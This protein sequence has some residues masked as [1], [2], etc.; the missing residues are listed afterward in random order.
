MPFSKERRGNWLA[1]TGPMMGRAGATTAEPAAGRAKRK[2]EDLS[3]EQGAA[4]GRGAAGAGKA[5][6][7]AKSMASSPP[8]RSPERVSQ[9][10]TAQKE[11]A[12]A[13]EAAAAATAD[14]SAEAESEWRT[15]GSA[16]VG[17][18]ILRTVQDDGQLSEGWGKI[19]GWLSAAESDFVNDD[20][21]P[22]ALWHVVFDD[23][24]L[25]EEDL[26]EH[27]V[28]AAVIAWELATREL[29]RGGKKNSKASAA[30]KGKKGKARGAESDAVPPARDPRVYFVEDADEH[31]GLPQL[32]LE[33]E[34]DVED[35]I[36]LNSERYKGLKNASSCRLKP[37]TVLI[38]PEVPE[39]SAATVPAAAGS[40]SGRKDSTPPL[41]PQVSPVAA[42]TAPRTTP[43]TSEPVAAKAPALAKVPAPAKALAMPKAPA[44]DAKAALLL[45]Q[46]ERNGTTHAASGKTP[47][48]SDSAGEA[49]RHSEEGAGEGG[50]AKG[51]WLMSMR[52]NLTFPPFP[53]VTEDM[54]V[55]AQEYLQHFHCPFI[56]KQGITYAAAGFEAVAPVTAEVCAGRV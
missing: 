21:T 35:I 16:Y 14:T 44:L 47:S 37:H 52:P 30:G 3:R 39:A 20:G 5:P 18:G 51:D 50:A 40:K 31:K 6:K 9:M 26:E 19:T 10:P 17:R 8:K 56:K 7:S 46:N 49:K 23:V 41:D 34:V 27:E 43:P 29:A 33:L 15:E 28:K 25:G 24:A 1:W 36:R 11:F 22:A 42:A 4:V 12:S 45:L 55:L 13:A 38:L 2:A 32:A 53:G 48:Q 54:G